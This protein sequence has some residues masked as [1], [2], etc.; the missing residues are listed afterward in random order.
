MR[1]PEVFRR[2]TSAR[3]RAFV[4]AGAISIVWVLWF[5]ALAPWSSLVVMRSAILLPVAL[6]ISSLAFSVIAVELQ[7]QFVPDLAWSDRRHFV[8]V[9]AVSAVVFIVQYIG[10]TTFMSAHAV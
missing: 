2:M 3:R 1:E 6:C 8:W 10:I 5:V 4:S 9:V 7:R